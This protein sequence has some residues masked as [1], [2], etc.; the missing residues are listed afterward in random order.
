MSKRNN[1]LKI[2]IIPSVPRRK[3]ASSSCR[4]LLTQEVLAAI[5]P[6]SEYAINPT[7]HFHTSSF[8]TLILLEST[9]S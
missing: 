6:P 2:G 8:L 5:N 1:S 3:Q 4:F 7:V 9:E